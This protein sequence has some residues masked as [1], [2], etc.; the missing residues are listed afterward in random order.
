MQINKIQSTQTPNNTMFQSRF[1][2]TAKMYNLLS[3]QT[4]N[5]Y[6][7]VVQDATSEINGTIMLVKSTKAPKMLEMVFIT[8][9]GENLYKKTFST[10]NPSEMEKI[11][12]SEGK[13]QS[14]RE[15]VLSYMSNLFSENGLKTINNNPF[16]KK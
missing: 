9:Q 6:Q 7:K 4:F 15:Q 3:D 12:S 10:I 13:E 1:R 16:L 2:G 14:I 5:T 11:A 8:P